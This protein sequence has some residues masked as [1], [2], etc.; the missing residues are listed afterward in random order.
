M[1]SLQLAGNKKIKNA[2]ALL[3]L[4]NQH[5]KTSTTMTFTRARAGRANT[6][7]NHF[8]VPQHAIDNVETYLSYYVIH[9]FTHCLGFPGHNASFK[10]RERK[11]L[12]LFDISIDY[13]RAYPKALYSNGEKVYQGKPIPGINSLRIT[14]HK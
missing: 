13:A 12:T 5:C 1:T 9:E 2:Q 7:L 6:E 14:Y 10:Q 8:T 4:L 11:L 3:E